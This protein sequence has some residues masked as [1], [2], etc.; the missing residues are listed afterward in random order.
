MTSKILGIDVGAVSGAWA[1]LHGSSITCGDLPV[2]DGNVSPAHL[3]QSLMAHKPDV[4]IVERVN[5]FSGQGVSS[6]WKFGQ[7]YGS[8]LACL[9]CAGIPVHLVTPTVWKKHYNLPGKDKEKARALAIRLF[10]TVEGLSRK[11]DHNRA[12]SLLLAR[13]HLET[14]K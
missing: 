2:V 4:A 9:A 13:Y 1:L 10:P 6:V 12:E 14:A 5:A 8:V 11:K 7:A 3:F